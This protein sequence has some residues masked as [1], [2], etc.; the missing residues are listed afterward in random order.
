M[1]KDENG[2]YVCG[3]SSLMFLTEDLKQAYMVP[4]LCHRKCGPDRCPKCSQEAQKQTLRQIREELIGREL[5]WAEL[6]E[7]EA[8][9][10]TD[11]L[12]YQN[13]AGDAAWV[14]FPLENGNFVI[15]T[16]I[17]AC[18]GFDGIP[19][20]D[21]LDERG[22]LIERWA[23]TPKG[24]RVSSSQKGRK[25]EKQ[26][27]GGNY[28]GA[29]S[30]DQEKRVRYTLEGTTNEVAAFLSK[31]GVRSYQLCG[32]W[33]FDDIPDDALNA[34]RKEFF[35]ERGPVIQVSEE[36]FDWEE[37]SAGFAKRAA[38]RLAAQAEVYA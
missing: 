4:L 15:L 16:A 11:N 1:A 19:L 28:A 37:A 10:V 27:F 18:K 23:Q 2:V 6:P 26:G 20:T 35:G 33:Q 24:K 12:Q 36:P 13:R 17:P 29:R 8:N 34:L 5:Y 25:R 38:E 32:K 30:H 9:K 21:D 31:R 22:A 7:A 3:S 14:K